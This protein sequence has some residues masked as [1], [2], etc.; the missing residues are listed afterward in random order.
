MTRFEICGELSVLRPFPSQKHARQCCH[1][2]KGR[3]KDKAAF[4]SVDNHTYDSG[5]R[6]AVI[7]AQV[8]AVRHDQDYS[9]GQSIHAH[10][11]ARMA[12]SGKRLR[13]WADV[14]LK[15]R[16]TPCSRRINF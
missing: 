4:K 10:S 7:P 8:G 9:H 14:G 2:S 16:R 11:E 1:Q 6:G 3:Q 12:Y 13:A 15:N 5:L